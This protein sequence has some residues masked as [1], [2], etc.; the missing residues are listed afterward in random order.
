MLLRLEVEILYLKDQLLM[1]MKLILTAADA[2]GGDKT[3]TL[4]NETGTILST[5]SSI[6][7]SNLANSSITIG[8]TSVA[9]GATQGT[10]A[11]LHLKHP[12][13]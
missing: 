2:T 8:S 12:L 13:H 4:P 7:N 10:F 5:A 6:A 3:L 11:G 1:Q 9:L